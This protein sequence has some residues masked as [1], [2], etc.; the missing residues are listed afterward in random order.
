MIGFEG[1]LPRKNSTKQLALKAIESAVLAVEVYNKP[2]VQFRTGAY[3]SLM[4]IAWTAAMHSIFERE[5]IQYF[6]KKKN[7][8]FERVDGEKKAW[9]LLECLKKYQCDSLT[10]D[11]RANLELFVRLRNRIEHRQMSALDAH[12]A[13][14]SQALL[15]N[16][17]TFLLAEYE[18][19]LLGDV[20]LY[21][22][23]SVFSA[24]RNIPQSA[25]ERAVISFVDRYRESLDAQVWQESK[26][27]FRAFL[28]PRI[29]NHQNSSDVTIE[30]I[31]VSGM[32]L[33]E[34]ERATRL[35]TMIRDR[36]VPMRKDLM[37][38]S[39]VVAK[40]KENYP[41]FT[42]SRFVN[43]WKALEVR[44][45]TN[46]ESPEKTN[47]KYCHYDPVDCD[48]RYEPQF[49]EELCRH[50]LNGHEFTDTT[51]PL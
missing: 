22:P 2:T 21:I 28:M 26:Y 17:K 37:K 1:K 4:I 49:V 11:V 12:I 19:E 15:L 31:P 20:G 35:A 10:E 16:L 24:K 9:E 46:S 30:F 50:L 27:A 45:L 25:E 23:I 51:Q 38:P 41:Q 42:M 48:Y 6:Y 43:A 18:I 32:S 39:A 33:H 47:T 29:G 14:E 40:V 36:Q 3:A 13:S 7:G 34:K 44:P 8:R 5:G